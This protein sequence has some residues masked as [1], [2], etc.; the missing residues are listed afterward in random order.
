MTKRGSRETLQTK[1]DKM[2][3][4]YPMT[5]EGN[6]KLKEELDHLKKVE[7]PAIV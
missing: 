5:V 2:A 6:K 7:R 4:K 3:T 1:D